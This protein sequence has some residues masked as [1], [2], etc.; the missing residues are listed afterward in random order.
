MRVEDDRLHP[1]PLLPTDRVTYVGQSIAIIVAE[2]RF[3]A[4]DAAE[5]VEIDYEMLPVVTDTRSALAKGAPLIEPA[6]G[7]NTISTKSRSSVASR[8]Y[9]ISDSV[10]I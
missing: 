5:L 2:T 1:I 8:G 3:A 9:L 6:W 10:S 4:M 7:T